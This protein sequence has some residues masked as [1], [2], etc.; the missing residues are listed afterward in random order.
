M[1]FLAGM[2]SSMGTPGYYIDSGIC[3]DC[4]TCLQGLDVA[5]AMDYTGSMH[6][7]IESVKVDISDIAAT[8]DSLVDPANKYRLALQLTDEQQYTVSSGTYGSTYLTSGVYT[9]LPSS[10]KYL[11]EGTTPTGN[12]IYPTGIKL[13]QALTTMEPFADNNLT[14]FQTQLAKTNNN[15]SPNMGLGSGNAAPEPYDMSIDKMIDGEVGV[16]PWRKA[17]SRIGLTFA[18]QAPS[19]DD[20]TFANVDE[21]FMLNDLPSKLRINNIRWMRFGPLSSYFK[22]DYLTT[23][24]DGAANDNYSN[25]VVS[26]A[27]IAACERGEIPYRMTNSNG[28]LKTKEFTPWSWNIGIHNHTAHWFEVVD[29]DDFTINPSTG[30]TFSLWIKPSELTNQKIFCK[31]GEYEIGTDSSDNLFFSVTTNNGVLKITTKIPPLVTTGWTHVLCTWNGSFTNLNG[32]KIRLGAA[33]PNG[34]AGASHVVYSVGN[35]NVNDDSTGSTGTSVTNTSNNIYCGGDDTTTA[36]YDGLLSDVAIYKENLTST[37]A[38]LILNSGRPGNLH[39][40]WN[41]I[42]KDSLVGYW[43]PLARQTVATSSSSPYGYVQYGWESKNGISYGFEQGTS[44]WLQQ[45]S[46][47]VPSS[48]GQ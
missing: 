14:S 39:S 20:D 4:E 46:V 9:G 47:D 24:S 29:H 22:W 48:L 3:T 43:R 32:L 17:V 45:W 27:I 36:E 1:G 2:P 7:I 30:M 41:D 37:Q 16:G 13:H 12:P 8:I 18:D 34:S 26:A 33:W 6:T 42:D 38:A 5:F 19:G 21:L 28:Y 44:G 10:Q 31:T 40:L 35:N 23:R 15:T 11:Q 25:A